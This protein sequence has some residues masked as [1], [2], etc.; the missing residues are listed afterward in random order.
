MKNSPAASH[1]ADVWG[2]AAFCRL[3]RARSFSLVYLFLALVMVLAIV[4]LFRKVGDFAMT[5]LADAPCII[6]IFLLWLEGSDLKKW[7]YRSFSWPAERNG[8]LLGLTIVVLPVAGAAVFHRYATGFWPELTTLPFSGHLFGLFIYYLVGAFIEDIAWRSYLLPRVLVLYP[9]VKTLCILAIFWTFW[10]FPFHL[11]LGLMGPEHFLE[12]L[13]VYPAIFFCFLLIY[14]LSEGSLWPLA[15]SHALHNTF[16][17]IIERHFVYTARVSDGWIFYD[18]RFVLIVSL[19]FAA[20]LFRKGGSRF[21][22]E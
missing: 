18:A 22:S 6:A 2:I 7:F 8:L 5:L 20:M 15:L 4:P 14:S 9:G 3:S 13:I 1:S 12:K 17:T 11:A 16:C 10:H 21:F 19:T